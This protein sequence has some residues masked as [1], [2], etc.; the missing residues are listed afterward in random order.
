MANGWKS[1]GRQKGTPNK[2]TMAR[3]ARIAEAAAA[4]ES[5]MPEAFKGD[6]H[7]YLMAV[8]KNPSLPTKDRLAAA[9]AAIGYEKPKLAAV[10]AQAE[11]DATV[12]VSRIELVAVVPRD[13]DSYVIRNGSAPSH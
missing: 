3:E 4:I 11:V 2:R 5:A 13:E 1:G 10:E 7:A 9:T 8:Y 12:A 6:A